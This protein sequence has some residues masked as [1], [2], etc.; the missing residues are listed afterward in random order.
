MKA[1]LAV[2]V[3]ARRGVV[4]SVLSRFIILIEITSSN[5]TGAFPITLEQGN[6]HIMVMENSD[7]G[8]IL[9]TTINQ[10]RK[11]TYWKDS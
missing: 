11:N 9:A 1:A 4:F 2:L 10:G 7:V 3:T 6:R 5:Q 8:L